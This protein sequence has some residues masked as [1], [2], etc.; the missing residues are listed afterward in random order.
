MIVPS[1]SS[2]NSGLHP[3]NRMMETLSIQV[4]ICKTYRESENQTN[5]C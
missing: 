2:T 5:Q 1:S 4:K 3:S